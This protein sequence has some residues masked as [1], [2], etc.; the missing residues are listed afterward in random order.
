MGLAADRGVTIC[1]ADLDGADGL[2]VPEERTILVNR[3]LS[4]SRVNEVIEHELAHVAIDDQHADLDAGVWEPRPAAGLFGNG[5]FGKRW[6][7]PVLSAAAFVALVGGV[8]LGLTAAIPDGTPREMTNGG[9]LPIP[10]ESGELPGPTTSLSPSVDADGN[11][12]YHTVT[13]TP[14]ARVT[15]TA[16]TTATVTASRS[17]PENPPATRR[18]AGTTPTL[19]PGATSPPPTATTAAPTPAP[20]STPDAPPTT[21]PVVTVSAGASVG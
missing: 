18:P 15:P 7:T 6:A 19:D 20:T 8:T 11:T 1:F 14:R 5:L 13:I 3:R 2:W 21:A 10:S 16:T 17:V 12:H 4:E 9:P